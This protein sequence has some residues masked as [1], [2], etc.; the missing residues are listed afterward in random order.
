ME[1]RVQ[2]EW[3]LSLA[4]N[5][6]SITGIIRDYERAKSNRGNWENHWQDIADYVLPSREFSQ[7]T[8]PGL[9]RRR[10]IYDST[11]PDAAET[12]SAAVHGML[13]NPASIWFGLQMEDAK[14]NDMEEVRLWLDTVVLQMLNIFNSPAVGFN[15]QSYEI[16]QDLVSFGTACLIDRTRLNQINFKASPLSDIYLKSDS[17]TDRINTAYREIEWTPVELVKEFG[18]KNVHA[19]ILEAVSDRDSDKAHKKG[20]YLHAVFPREDRDILKRDA[21]NKAFVSVYIDIANKHQLSLSG[22]DDFPYITPRWSKA[23]G[24][25]YGRSPA[26]KMLPEIMTVNAMTRTCLIGGEKAVSPPLQVMANMIKGPISTKP[27]SLIYVKPMAGGDAIKPIMM[28]NNIQLGEA[29]IEV[30]QNRIRQG[31]YLNLLELPQNDRMTAVE[32]TRRIQQQMQV[33]SP[34]VSRQGSELLQPL[35]IRNFKAMAALGMLLPPPEVIAGRNMIV[36]FISPLAVSQRA[37]SIG[38][39]Q[40]H[41]SVMF[42]FAEA[43]PLVL[44]NYNTD[45][46]HRDSAA[47]LNVPQRFINSRTTVQRIRQAR[48]QAMRQRE[49][50]EQAEQASKAAKNVEGLS[51]AG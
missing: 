25:T 11:G 7:T 10:K 41:M 40:Q 26:M 5:E 47:M 21:G 24:E 14:L 51:L 44:D 13:F 8:T 48:N 29:M 17:S 31:F 23:T 38:S 33:F 9:K 43:D 6:I 27:N 49:M 46:I 19:N 37:S 42:P 32:V 4:D 28:G 39:L 45:T 20:N 16:I 18:E 12:L 34:V 15:T 36:E 1:G 3:S 2:L 30:R 22:M 50:L 35:V